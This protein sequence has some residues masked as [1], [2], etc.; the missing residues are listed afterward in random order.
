MVSWFVCPGRQLESPNTGFSQLYI[1]YLWFLRIPYHGSIC[2]YLWRV[3]LSHW[4]S[5]LETSGNYQKASHLLWQYHLWCCPC[6][7][8]TVHLNHKNPCS[9]CSS[10]SCI[11][12]SPQNILTFHQCHQVKVA[13]LSLHKFPSQQWHKH[14]LV[15]LLRKL[16]EERFT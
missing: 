15:P 2:L 4:Q 13:T 1:T 10:W 5:K 16:R 8:C 12:S 9:P 7:V 3:H 14:F 11:W 6:L